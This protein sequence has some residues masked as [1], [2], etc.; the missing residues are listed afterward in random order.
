MIYPGLSIIVSPWGMTATT[1]LELFFFVFFLPNRATSAFLFEITARLRTKYL[2][3]LYWIPWPIVA[4]FYMD[5]KDYY[6][7]IVKVYEVH[8]R[9]R[10]NSM[11]IVCV[12]HS[13]V[14][15]KSRDHFGQRIIYT[16]MSVLIFQRKNKTDV[17]WSLTTVRE[18][19][20][21]NFSRSK[22]WTNIFLVF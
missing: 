18:C 20:W 21:P 10:K 13:I 11:H 2:L 4:H 5:L 6:I 8:W 14:C 1:Q 12:W 15:I 7:W 19:V 17:C 9:D 3:L 22:N 16:P